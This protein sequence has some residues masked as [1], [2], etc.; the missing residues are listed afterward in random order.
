MRDHT[1]VSK[2]AFLLASMVL[3]L[4][5][6]S[7]AAL[8]VTTGAVA[9]DPGNAQARDAVLD[10]SLKALVA[11]R[12]GPPGVIAVVQRG[13]HREVHAFGI[14]NIKRSLPMRERPHAHGE[15]LQGLQR[16]RRPLAGKRWQ[17]LLERH[18]RRTTAGPT[19]DPA[20]N[21]APPAPRPHQRAPEFYRGPRLPGVALGQPRE[22]APT[23]QVALL[24]G[25]RK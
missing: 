8:A 9:R 3:A 14:R 6:A 1:H 4:V 15:H 10:A 25:G 19:E 16:C 22:C 23:P 20:R 24:R 17:A 2:S 21:H 12:G 5:L 13:H 7:G 18:D 11:R